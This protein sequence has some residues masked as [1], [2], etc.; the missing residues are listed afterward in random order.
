MK[1]NLSSR[2]RSKTD[3]YVEIENKTKTMILVPSVILF[4]LFRQVGL[5]GKINY[6]GFRTVFKDNVST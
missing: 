2:N 6:A 1:L 5:S 4:H 3:N